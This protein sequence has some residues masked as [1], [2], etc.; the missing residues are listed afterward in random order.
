MP[1][2][3]LKSCSDISYHNKALKSLTRYRLDKV[4]ERAKLTDTHTSSQK[5]DKFIATLHTDFSLMC[6][7][8][9]YPEDSECRKLRD[10]FYLCVDPSGRTCYNPECVMVFL[11]SSFDT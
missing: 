8:E 10:S 3:N 9:H 1:D 2:V 6:Q 4:K 7:T 5:Y 11:T